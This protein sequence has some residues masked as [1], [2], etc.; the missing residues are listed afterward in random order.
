MP[1][2]ATLD[3]TEPMADYPVMSKIGTHN[4]FHPIVEEARMPKETDSKTSKDESHTA[5]EA[6]TSQQASE[7][8]AKD[9]FPFTAPFADFGDFNN[10]AFEAY[11]RT[12]QAIL[13]NAA[14]L[15]QELMRFAGERFQ[16]DLEA[17]QALPGYTNVQGVVSFQ[18]DFMRRAAEAYQSEFSKIMQQSTEAMSAAVEPLIESVKE[19]AKEGSRK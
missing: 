3:R 5:A 14:A 16:T 10:N 4:V 1:S 9:E 15:N 2:P 18:S 6:V 17:M 12:S 11:I 13:E 19:S 8:A 7:K